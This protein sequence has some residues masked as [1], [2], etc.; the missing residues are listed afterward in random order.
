MASVMNRLACFTATMGRRPEASPAAMAAL[1]VHPVP[2]VLTVGIL[3][4]GNQRTSPLVRKRSSAPSPFKCPPVMRTWGQPK[5]CNFRA[6]LIMS[7]FVCTV[8]PVSTWAS[9]MLG[10]TTVAKG[11]NGG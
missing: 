6:A 8:M 1:R 4:A 2:W 5:D 9:G 11:N 7:S 10:V 3:V